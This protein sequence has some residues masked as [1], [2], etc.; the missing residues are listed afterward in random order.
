MAACGGKL[1]TAPNDVLDHIRIYFPTRDT[2]VKSTGGP[3]C[4][5]VINLNRQF[6]E[7]KTFPKQCMRDYKSTRQGVLSHNKLLLA[8]GRKTDGT[9]FAW[10]YVGSANLS[11]AA[12][13]RQNELKSGKPGKLSINNW[14][15]GVVVPV[16]EENLKALKLEDGEVPPIS[17]FEG[18]VETP[19]QYPGEEYGGKQPWYFLE[20]QG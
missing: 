1:P 14:E 18:V 6:Y 20:H 11:E 2:V 19:F 8:R 12:W 17:V 9:P 13:G 4:G 3:A 15:S 5:G 10:V 7:S 16:P